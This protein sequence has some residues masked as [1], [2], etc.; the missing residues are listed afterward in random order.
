[1]R[2]RE[3]GCCKM[4][5]SAECARTKRKRERERE[6]AES[7]CGGQSK[8]GIYIEVVGFDCQVPALAVRCSA[9]LSLS[10]RAVIAALRQQPATAVAHTVHGRAVL[11]SEAEWKERTRRHCGRPMGIVHKNGETQKN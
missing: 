4:G 5:R 2:E 3:K 8:G 10:V 11:L 9:L 6:R 1:M 7:S